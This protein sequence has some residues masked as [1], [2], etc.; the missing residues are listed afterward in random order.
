MRVLQKNGCE[1]MLPEGQTCCG[2][3]HV[4]VGLRATRRG[5]WR[6]ATSTPSSAGGFDA[7]ITNAAGCGSTLKEYHELLER[8]SRV[9]REGAHVSRRS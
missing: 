4:H 9:R 7:I 2:A 8:R 5:G 1:V 6:G 3:L